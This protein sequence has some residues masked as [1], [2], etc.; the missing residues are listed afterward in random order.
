MYNLLEG[1]DEKM[2][3]QEVL[4]DNNKK[5]YILLDEE[6]L[7]VVEAVRYLKYLDSIGRSINTQKTYCYA[8]KH[9]FTFL[10]ES[11]LC[12]PEISINLLSDFIIWLKNPYHSIKVTPISESPSNKTAKTINLILTVVTN[13]YDYLYRTELLHTDISEKIKKSSFTIGAFLLEGFSGT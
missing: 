9:Y 6:G 13:F 8:L 7:P 5:R 11:S 1:C 12:I 2:R 3:V 4:L 10:K